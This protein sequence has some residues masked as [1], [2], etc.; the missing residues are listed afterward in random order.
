MHV[1]LFVLGLI[2]IAAATLLYP[3]DEKKLQN[4]IE[5]LWLLATQL[6]PTS[7]T[8]LSSIVAAAA[9]VVLRIID[10]SFGAKLISVSAFASAIVTSSYSF[11]IVISA[12]WYGSRFMTDLSNVTWVV[13]I[14]VPIAL[15]IWY[16]KARIP[17][18]ALV[19]SW[20]ASLIKTEREILTLIA[21]CLG[22]V[23]DIGA[24]FVV[25][26]LLRR[27]L[28][29]KSF[30]AA[31]RLLI[32]HIALVAIAVA[33][34]AGAPWLNRVTERSPWYQLVQLA[35][36]WTS[37]NAFVVIAATTLITVLSLMA[38]HRLIWPLM[39][40]TLYRIATFG[41][42]EHRKVLFTTGVALICASST[43]FASAIGSLR[44]AIGF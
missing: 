37:S 25:R 21:I 31:I 5:D 6:R 35:G 2:L 41:V 23:T 19:V 30:G 42:F 22:A 29:F 39:E 43:T 17:T 38:I 13:E 11:Y 3:D 10:R 15:V 14:T 27:F 40:R 7:E 36:Y 33:P 28:K 9:T 24:L 44:K 18:A 1:V 12:F 26:T 32:A 16:P 20:M 34:F 8:R 4:R